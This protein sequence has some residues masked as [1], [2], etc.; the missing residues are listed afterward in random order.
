MTNARFLKLAVLTICLLAA[1]ACDPQKFVKKY[2]GQMGLNQLATPRD[3]LEPGA[4]FLSDKKKVSYA[5]NM[6]D[7]ADDT[8]DEY[9]VG[10]KNAMY[11]FNAALR[12]GEEERTVEPTAALKFLDAVL[13]VNVSGSLKFTSKVTI[14]PVNAKAKRMKIPILQRYLNSPDSLSFRRQMH[15]FQQR[16]KNLQVA[17]AYEIYRTNSMRITAEGGKDVSSELKVGA[18]GPVGSGALGFKYKKTSKSELVIEGDRFYAFAARAARIEESKAFSK[19]YL[20]T[21]LSFVFPG[22]WGIQAAG[23]DITYSTSIVGDDFQP[24]DF[25]PL[26]ELGL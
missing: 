12:S 9:P 4:V 25:V 7:Y 23:T 18:V 2:Y 8:E 26:T 3:D 24:L 22:K 13:P 20:L 16:N 5:D 15:D 6:L 19:T 17:I 11:L 14:A 1:S 10:V 21:D